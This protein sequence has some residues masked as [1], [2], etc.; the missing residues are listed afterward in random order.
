MDKMIQL[1]QE[2]ILKAVTLTEGVL[3]REINEKELAGFTENRDR[4]YQIIDQISR[5]IE[6]NQIDEETKTEFNRQIDYLKKLD[7]KL[8][9]KLQEHQIA[10]RKE[11]EQTHRQKEN[12]RGYNLNDTTK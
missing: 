11:I 2:F 9:V 5:Q 10:L 7:E 1:F 12:V 4:L 8:L 6:W 3:A